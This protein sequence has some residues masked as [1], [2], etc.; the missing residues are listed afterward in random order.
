MIWANRIK[1]IIYFLGAVFTLTLFPM[2]Y[3]ISF[4][5]DC[6]WD[7]KKLIRDNSLV[8][9]DFQNTGILGLRL[10]FQLIFMSIGFSQQLF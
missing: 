8:C 4:F 2:C 5:F 6:D 9:W 3:G 10:L 1:Y 7:T